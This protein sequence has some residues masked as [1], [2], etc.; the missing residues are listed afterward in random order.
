MKECRVTLTNEVAEQM[1][2]FKNYKKQL[3]ESIDKPKE[4]SGSFN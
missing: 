1:P 3:Y 2:K 4:V